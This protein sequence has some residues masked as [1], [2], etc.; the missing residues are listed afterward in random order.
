MSMGLFQWHRMYSSEKDGFAFLNLQRAMT[1]YT[2]PTIMIVRPTS[3]TSYDGKAA[4]TP[5]LLGFYT[6]NEWKESKSFYGDSDCFLFRA[7]PTWNVYR[8]RRF[9]Q[10][11][12][13]GVGGGERT[14]DTDAAY[15]P[16]LLSAKKISDNYMY[17]H[18]SAGHV[19]HSGAAPLGKLHPQQQGKRSG[20]SQ[21]HQSCQYQL[22][23]SKSTWLVIPPL[24]LSLMIQIS[25]EIAHY[26]TTD[27]V[28]SAIDC[29]TEKKKNG[30]KIPWLNQ[31]MEQS[32]F[33]AALP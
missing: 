23:H 2:G 4:E 12:N 5:G 32:D 27:E 1:G 6:C 22:S 29:F 28:S 3:A 21:H 25:A 18:P 17:F 31:N 20:K 11:W 13:H 19:R 9:V 30:V 7:E 8:P 14:T 16:S 10:S 15:P 33:S 24:P 26:R